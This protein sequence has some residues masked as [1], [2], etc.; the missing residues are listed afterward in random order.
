M[1]KSLLTL[2][3]LGMITGVILSVLFS[4]D[5]LY[6]IDAQNGPE[7]KVSLPPSPTPNPTVASLQMP[8]PAT[9]TPTSVVA[10]KTP[11]PTKCVVDPN[12]LAMALKKYSS[13]SQFEDTL[14]SIVS[15]I[16]GCK[17]CSR[18][19]QKTIVQVKMMMALKAGKQK[20]AEKYMKQLDAFVD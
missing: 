8:I 3:F 10:S 2:L 5:L 18:K 1:L 7:S 16:D 20:T 17:K 6:I 15:K 13:D 4:D 12:E 9:P 11:K 19:E 14:L